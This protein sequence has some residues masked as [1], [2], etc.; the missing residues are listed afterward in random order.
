[1]KEFIPKL[2]PNGFVPDNEIYKHLVS[3]TR[4]L[5]E[6]NGL[7]T[8]S[9]LNADILLNSLMLQEAKDS[10]AIENI[11][12]TQDELFLA[13][14]DEINLTP[15]TKEVL[16]Y[17]RALSTGFDLVKKDKLLLNKHI[18]KIQEE[19]EANNAGFRSQ[20]GTM[21]K[22]QTTGEI[23]LIP[24][25]NNSD[26]LRLMDNLQMYIN[27]E[28][29]DIDPLIRVG[30]I[31]YQFETI[32]PFYDG[33]GRT[34]RIINVLYLVQKGFL[35]LPILYLSAY[36]I[37]NKKEYY[38]LFGALRNDNKA[39]WHQWTKWFL[40]GI[41]KTS[42]ATTQIINDIKNSML[43]F[44]EFLEQNTNFYSKDL[45]EALFWYPYTKIDFI[46]NRLKIHR[47]TASKYL[48]TCEKLG[49]LKSIKIG[50][51]IYYINLELF[52]ILENGI[53]ERI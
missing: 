16:N 39:D 48:K 2:L 32:H 21:L 14:A 8:S 37:K 6:L 34:G 36:I 19:L 30:I 11:I 52:N 7:I 10:S 20:P 40:I 41:E 27:D 38:E 51:N 24:P 5:G 29:D 28:L 12:T 46:Q 13:Q 15:Q 25:Q 45:V 31:H 26:I 22:N 44:S 17:H 49:K 42:R 3:A 4:A 50:R 1:M 23:K 53:Y 18:L 43:N 35:K 9:L 33:N 47:D